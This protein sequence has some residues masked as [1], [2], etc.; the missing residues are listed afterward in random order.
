MSWNEEAAAA[1][2]SFRSTKAGHGTYERAAAVM[3]YQVSKSGCYLEEAR[4]CIAGAPRKFSFRN[5]SFS[6]FGALQS[7]T[8][9]RKTRFQ[10]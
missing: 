5:G 7:L 1:M 8:H 6:V 9:T 2:E 3:I 4:R 10:K